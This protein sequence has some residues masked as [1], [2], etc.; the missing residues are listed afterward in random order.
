MFRPI[1]S[2][3]VL[4]GMCATANATPPPPPA[5]VQWKRLAWECPARKRSSI[6]VEVSAQGDSGYQLVVTELQIDG[7]RV[8]PS[9]VDGLQEI[10]ARRNFLRIAS[11]Y[12]DHTGETIGIEELASGPKANEIGWTSLRIAYPE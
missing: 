4:L 10:L 1:V 12:C 2:A 8:D 3:A 11:S 5:P 7:R 9:S 6:E